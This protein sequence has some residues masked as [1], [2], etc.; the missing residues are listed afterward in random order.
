[1]FSGRN[2]DSKRAVTR[3]RDKVNE[4]IENTSFFQ[5]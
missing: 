4:I 3:D 2:K 5:G 1:M